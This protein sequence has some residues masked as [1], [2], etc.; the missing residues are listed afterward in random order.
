M[1]RDDQRM[2][3]G[4]QRGVQVARTCDPARRLQAAGEV[5][6][7]PVWRPGSLR[8]GGGQQSRAA[9]SS[10][11]WERLRDH[12]VDVTEKPWET[13]SGEPCPE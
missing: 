4:S 8:S 10:M 3:G 11:I 9:F 12:G 2:G 6:R 5:Q 7:R 1:I 13:H